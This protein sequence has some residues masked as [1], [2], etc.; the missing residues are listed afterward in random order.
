MKISL[1]RGLLALASLSVAAGLG[2]V[3]LKL[4][5]AG[6]PPTTSML[7]APDEGTLIRLVP[8]SAKVFRRHE[9]LGGGEVDVR[10]NSLG[11][12]GEQF[13]LQKQG[14]RVMVYGDSFI[15]AEFS[16]LHETFVVRLG[17][18]L[19]ERLGRP[20]QT[21]NAGVIGFGPDQSL[22][23]MERELPRFE[24]DLVVF[25]IFSG[26]DYG[27][28]IRNRLFRLDE[29][30]AL[31]RRQVWLGDDLLSHWEET[32]SGPGAE[33]PE[34]TGAGPRRPMRKD[35]PKPPFDAVTYTERALKASIRNFADAEAEEVLVMNMV[36]PDRHDADIAI[37]PGQR[38]SRHKVAL[39]EEI[40]AEAGRVA[41]RQ[42]V[43]LAFLFIP[44]LIDVCASDD[45]AVDT[46]RWPTYER[47]RLCGI[48]EEIA[49]RQLLPALNLYSSFHEQDP[50][51]LYF[52]RDDQ[53][54]NAA[55]QEL[56][57]EV[58]ARF[59]AQQGWLGE[60]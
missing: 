10:I 48:L 40:M 23:K 17:D 29:D 56:A 26:N 4:A 54:W 1:A 37:Y 47:R 18:L 28:L 27:D 43:P 12:R 7:Y 6:A 13:P 57:A 36:E 42:G 24:P 14:L 21:I 33:D 41:E 20:V 31:E 60:G 30:G 9:S 52:G 39:M 25:A 46:L 32:R 15:E 59:I 55:G 2:Y 22:I 49:G 34:P 44:A 19:E 3:V 45:V 35:R 11:F 5:R 51:A 16:P 38:K 53:H 50:C 58:T 8:N